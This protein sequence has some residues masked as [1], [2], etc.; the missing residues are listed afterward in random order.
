MRQFAVLATALEVIVG[1]A[2]DS[3]DALRTA[4]EAVSA[5]LWLGDVA[6]ATRSERAVPR[7]S[8]ELRAGEDG[9]A[10]ASVADDDD[11]PGD[12]DAVL[13]GAR[14]CVMLTRVAALLGIAPPELRR[15]LL[16]R[17]LST[18]RGSTYTVH[19]SPAQAADCRDACA[20]CAFA[21]VCR[22]PCES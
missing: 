21:K 8:E 9:S 16:S 13:A 7:P 11:I 18:G 4:F 14:S 22:T 15:A 2:D 3:C 5:V 10:A 1:P 12:D 6:F 20:K 19:L 17:S